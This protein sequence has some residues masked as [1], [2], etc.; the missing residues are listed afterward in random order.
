VNGTAEFESLD[1]RPETSGSA[2]CALC[3]AIT[4]PTAKSKYYNTILFES[5][6][7]VVLPAV[8]P[9]RRGHVMVVSRIHRASLAD[10]ERDD[11]AEYDRLA[12]SIRGLPE[13][14]D[15]VEVEHGSTHD[16]PSGPC[17]R[18][19]HIHWLP[20]SPFVSPLL[21]QAVSQKPQPIN[22]LAHIRQF[23]RPYLFLR[24]PNQSAVFMVDPLPSQFV[25]RVICE[26]LGE[27]DW[28]W[29]VSP[30]EQTIRETIDLWSNIRTKPL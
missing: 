27:D 5:P 15:A 10:L 1:K 3:D 4:S 8:G 14:A 12:S 21:Q 19:A 16:G 29:A 23:P 26:Y 28:D 13:Y 2:G 9:L 25:R 24:T 6:S 30:R 22:R 7:F 17:V 18:H 11:I 20:E